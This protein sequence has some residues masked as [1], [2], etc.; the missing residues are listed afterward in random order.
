MKTMKEIHFSFITEKFQGFGPFFMDRFLLAENPM[1][2]ND[3]LFII[4][5]IDPPMIIQVHHEAV[6]TGR[7]TLTVNYQG[8]SGLIETITLEVVSSIDYER[9]SSDRIAKLL[10]RAWHWYKAYLEWEDENFDED[11][12]AIQN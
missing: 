6:G 3:D 9:I 5:T 4:H 8:S 12:R 11:E 10:N 2:E 1:R 7:A